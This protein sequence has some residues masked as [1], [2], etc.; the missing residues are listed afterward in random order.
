VFADGH[1]SIVAGKR[2]FGAPSVRA[3]LMSSPAGEHLQ[4]ERIEQLTPDGV[5][6]EHA[7]ADQTIDRRLPARER[8][9]GPRV[10]RGAAAAAARRTAFADVALAV[11][12]SRLAVWFV[13]IYAVL[14]VGFR[15]TGGA[16]HT[17]APLGNLG[18]LIFGLAQRWDG[19]FYLSIADHSYNSAAISAF[20]PFYPLTIKAVGVVTGSSL[21][22]GIAISLTSFA[23]ALYLLHRLVT[24]ELGAE[25]A[26]TAVLVLAF[27]P[28]SLF[29]SAVYPEALLLALTIGAVYA[30]RTGH[31]A[32]AGI[33]GALSAATHNAGILVA[34]PIALLY[35]YGPRA[36]RDRPVEPST[37][38][39]LPRYHP[40]LNFLWIALI[41]LGLVAFLAYM[42]V[43][44][45]DALRPFQANTTFW[46][47]HFVLL[48]G[49][50]GIV[51]VVWHGLHTIASAP[52]SLLFPATDGPY[53]G[54][55]INIVDAT[56]LIFALFATI[57]VIRRLPAAY[58]LY[59]VVSL[60]VFISA[61]KASEP[62]ASLPRYIL[63]LFPLQMALARWLDERKW[64]GVWL[65]CSGLALGAASMQFATGRWVG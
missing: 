53:R 50:P 59:T 33:L 25:H 21:I 19:V 49:I 9:L 65:A 23:V 6:L 28:T 2:R 55:A 20:F 11:W 30:A 18:Q 35:L 39:W 60:A 12:T 61:P 47:R 7:A 38:R 16:P 42:G 8:G 13:S 58:S 45:G 54:A 10:A 5:Q 51:S 63:V 15:P 24:L 31:W 40:R 41:P 52:P 14:T 29:F 44:H 62:L 26:R 22:A 57:G 17:G 4:H 32:W 46:H 48:G 34:I 43:E 3:Q 1:H 37:I 56:A 36:D 27:F 64:L